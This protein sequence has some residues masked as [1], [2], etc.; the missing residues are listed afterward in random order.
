MRTE[1]TVTRDELP[2]GQELGKIV[3][4]LLDWE[5]PPSSAAV[6]DDVAMGVRLEWSDL[7]STRVGWR[8]PSSWE[9]EGLLFGARKVERTTAV[10]VSARWLPFI[11]ARLEAVA[12]SCSTASARRVWAMNLVFTGGKHLV[13]TLG[14]LKSGVPS[15]IP[16][17]LLVT[18][19]ESIARAYWPSNPYGPCTESPA[20]GTLG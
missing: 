12:W 7:S 16:D 4:E 1:P 18:A 5:E 8:N 13:I 3:Y 2:V 11:G 19:S 17:N 20:C 9:E 6:I 14:E 15:Y 10:D